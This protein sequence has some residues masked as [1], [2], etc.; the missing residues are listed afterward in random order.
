MFSLQFPLAQPEIE[1]E[2]HAVEMYLMLYICI[3]I[4]RETDRERDGE[5]PSEIKVISS[6][7]MKLQLSSMMMANSIRSCTGS[8]LQIDRCSTAASHRASPTCS[9]KSRANNDEQLKS[10]CSSHSVSYFHSLAGACNW[11]DS[12][13]F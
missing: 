5:R 8:P 2:F 4:E 13:L 3:Y 11:P 12:G 6:A 10:I 7:L 1:S 9:A